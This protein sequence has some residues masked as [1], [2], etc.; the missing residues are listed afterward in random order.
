MEVNCSKCLLR[1]CQCGHMYR[2]WSTDELEGAIR[3][4]QYVL[5]YPGINP[6]LDYPLAVNGEFIF[7]P[8]HKLSL[9]ERW[10]SRKHRF[11]V[12]NLRPGSQFRFRADFQPYAL[13]EVTEFQTVV[14]ADFTLIDYYGNCVYTILSRGTDGKEY[15]F[16]TSDHGKT[17]P[18]PHVAPKYILRKD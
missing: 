18:N 2:N 15:F 17:E 11:P 7:H 4:M 12:D 1:V 10:K 9:W 13:G 14:T 3:T 16:G 8:K 6:P 5:R